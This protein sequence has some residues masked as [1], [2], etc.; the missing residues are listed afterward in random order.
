MTCDVRNCAAALL[1]CLSVLSAA[2]GDPPPRYVSIRRDEANLRE[3]PSYAHR[4][5]WVYKRK[6]YPLKVVARYDAWVRVKDVDGTVGWMHRTQLSDRRTVLFIGFT[7][8]PLRNGTGPSARIVA[9]AEPGVVARLRA[10]KP[11]FCEIDAQGTDGWV[12]R[13]NIWG[14]DAGEVIQ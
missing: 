9:W 13:K 1:L 7:K 8:S 6:D 4:I 5:L 11:R 10:C 12:D 3:G 14:V 2:A